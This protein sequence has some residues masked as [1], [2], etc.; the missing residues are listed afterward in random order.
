[1]GMIEKKASQTRGTR[2]GFCAPGIHFSS[3][4]TLAARARPPQAKKS[5][6]IAARERVSTSSLPSSPVRCPAHCPTPPDAPLVTAGFQLRLISPR[7]WVR[8]VLPRSTGSR[9]GPEG[10]DSIS[11]HRRCLTINT[12]TLQSPRQASTTQHSYSSTLVSPFCSLRSHSSS[13][14]FH[15]D[16]SIPHSAHRSDPRLPILTR[17]H[18]PTTRPTTRPSMRAKLPN[19]QHASEYVSFASVEGLCGRRVRP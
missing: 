7:L 6:T 4:L 12:T 19:F 10:G 14:Y 18:R 11:F 5:Q 13:L 1:M 15:S 2:S 9:R 3:H 16:D 8:P 17:S